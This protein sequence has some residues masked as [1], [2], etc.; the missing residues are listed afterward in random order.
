MRQHLD[1]ATL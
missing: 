1:L